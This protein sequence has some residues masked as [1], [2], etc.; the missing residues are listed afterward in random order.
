[1]AYKRASREV[2]ARV[3][4]V[5]RDGI[6]GIKIQVS[7]GAQGTKHYTHHVDTLSISFCDMKSM[8]KTFHHIMDELLQ[9]WQSTK[10]AISGEKRQ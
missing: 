7:Y 3:T 10:Q 8:G 6:N 4:D 5:Y 1:M 9:E 2:G